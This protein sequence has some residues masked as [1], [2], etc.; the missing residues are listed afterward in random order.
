[1]IVT[2]DGV[3]HRCSGYEA[4]VVIAPKSYP[5]SWAPTLIVYGLSQCDLYGVEEED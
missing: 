1:M 2:P 3:G 4:P 5:E